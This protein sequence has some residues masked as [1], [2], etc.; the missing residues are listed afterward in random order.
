MFKKMNLTTKICLLFIISFIIFFA[1]SEF[2]TER[3]M[4]NQEKITIKKFVKNKLYKFE[5]IKNEVESKALYLSSALASYDIF[6]KAYEIPDENEGREYL[7][8][9]LTPIVENIK[10]ENNLK[11]L[12]VHFHKP[13]AKSFLRVWRKPGQRDGGDDISS[14]RKTIL[15]VY[16][17][18]KPVKGIEIG[19]GGFV[20]RG[21]SPIFDKNGNYLGSV[22][23][24]ISFNEIFKKLKDHKYENFA[25]I[26]RSELLNIARKLKNKPRIGSFVLVTSTNR[27]K[28]LNISPE[29]IDKNFS[30]NLKI[31]YLKNGEVLSFIPV[32]DFSGKLIGE[33]LYLLNPSFLT[34]EIK[35]SF[36]QQLI[37]LI[38]LIIIITLITIFILRNS[39]KPLKI[40]GLKL[41]EFSEGEADLSIQLP[42]KSKDEIGFVSEN[43][44]K[45]INNLHENIKNVKLGSEEVN[46]KTIIALRFSTL[47]EKSNDKIVKEIDE[48]SSAV[49]ELSASIKEVSNNIKI[50]SEQIEKLD[51]IKE[52]IQKVS[53]NVKNSMN[54][55]K[56]EVLSTTKAV[57]DI[58]NQITEM[59]NK[60]E[61]VTLK[62][63]QVVDNAENIKTKIDDT[64]NSI[65]NISQEIEAISSAVN[66]QSA[67][68]ENVANN[69]ENARQLSE[70]TLNK[71]KDGMESLQNLLGSIDRIK[72]KVFKVGDEINNLSNMAE[73][74]GKITNTIDEISE[75]T[76]LLALNAAIEAARA[77]EHGK[78]FAVVADEVRKLAERSASA[79][80]EIGELIKKIQTN[81]ELATKLTKESVDEVNNGIE[82]ADNTKEATEKIIEA[83]ENTYH[84]MEQVKNAAEEQALVSSQIVESV[85]KTTDNINKILEITMEL[86]NSGGL[87]ST[88]IDEINNL[89]IEVK[90]I[91]EL[92][93]SNVKTITSTAQKSSEQVNVTLDEIENQFKAIKDLLEIIKE[94]R[95]YADQVSNAVD[96]QLLVTENTV[97]SVNRMIENIN[98]NIKTSKGLI[99]SLEKAGITLSKLMEIVEKFKLKDEFVLEAAGLAHD[100]F[101]EK[102]KT[103][104][105]KNEKIDVSIITD[106]KHCMFGQWYYRKQE[107]YKNIKEFVDIES[108]HEKV[109]TTAI[110]AIKEHNSGNY[111]KRDELLKE[112]DKYRIEI[113]EKLDNLKR[114][115]YSIKSV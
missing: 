34:K 103:E 55:T 3:G 109:H 66:E 69:T 29:L 35:K 17:N 27:E 22:E 39:L 28:F 44:N 14:F 52:D 71:A 5:D 72:E 101:V 7:R 48:V 56:D 46:L 89:I 60:F 95:L 80:K 85:S 75:Q 12:K 114:V 90:Q 23:V 113:K 84:L 37:I 68:I 62:L 43:F 100:I 18:H 41:K 88:S 33:I 73:D 15:Y 107:D 83:S 21:V 61:T 81:V 59:A 79:T 96:E 40:L 97:N 92:Q 6:K 49:N 86:E 105:L 58:A 82:L 70:D 4:K 93:A 87:I 102:V 108:I 57:E 94:S 26:M 9:V 2:E 8:K 25:L 64:K 45:L 30:E 47:L 74:I 112:L 63:E 67:S 98:N 110:E 99:D 20:E 32:K 115:L 31:I 78:G 19:R 53:D 54:L 65:E 10:S 51:G 24:L 1:I 11:I 76:N 42:V 50:V 16:K 13:P 111:K 77:G 104:I 106:H 91:S 38:P 36:Y